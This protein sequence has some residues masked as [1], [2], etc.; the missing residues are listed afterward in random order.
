MKCRKDLKEERFI[1]SFSN[2][3]ETKVQTVRT[4]LRVFIYEVVNLSCPHG[5][6][7]DNTTLTDG[8][9]LVS[10]DAEVHQID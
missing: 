10:Y 8:L 2:L 7:G 1:S 3:N 6:A 5:V 9:V 4:N